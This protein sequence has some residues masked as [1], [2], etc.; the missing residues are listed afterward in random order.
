MMTAPIP[1][2]YPSY[3]ALTISARLSAAS[4]TVVVEA[5]EDVD[6]TVVVEAVDDLDAT[7]VVE[8]VDG[9]DVTVVAEGSASVVSVG[10]LLAE[11]E[12]K[13]NTRNKPTIACRRMIHTPLRRF[14]PSLSM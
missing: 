4:A 8:A 13:V 5:V 2:V 3:R 1:P 12:A 11:Q 14:E 9:L 6:A 10:S 7:V